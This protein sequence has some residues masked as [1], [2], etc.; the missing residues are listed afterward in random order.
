MNR[1][2]VLLALALTTASTAVFA[3]DPATEKADRIVLENKVGSVMASTGG[4]YQAADIG[5]EFKSG[6]SLMVND[7]AEATVVYYYLDRDGN[8]RRK[9]VEKYPGPDTYVIDDSCVPA[10]AWWSGKRD[11]GVLVGSALIGA[12][13]LGGGDGDDPPPVS[14]GAN[15]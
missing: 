8:V 12:A 10:V 2:T 4:D 7:K 1:H 15:R 3:Q 6:D 9:C 11:V 13:L 14:A 5:R